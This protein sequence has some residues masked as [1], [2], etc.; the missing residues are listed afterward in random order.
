MSETSRPAESGWK[1]VPVE[2]TQEMIDAHFAAHAQAETVFAE[3][4]AIWSAML[5]AAPSGTM[6]P[7]RRA[8]IYR[9]YQ[10]LGWQDLKDALEDRSPS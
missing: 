2:P 9:A 6:V 3:V 5:A 8:L 10:A 7:V 1:C 4:P